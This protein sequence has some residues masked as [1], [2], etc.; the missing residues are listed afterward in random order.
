M[1]LSSKFD[2]QKF[3]VA[4]AA[5]C[6]T[7][8]EKVSYLRSVE[9]FKKLKHESMLEKLRRW[10]VKLKSGRSSEFRGCRY[11]AE[12]DNLVARDVKHLLSILQPNNKKFNCTIV[13][14]DILEGLLFMHCASFGMESVFLAMKRGKGWAVDFCRR[15]SF[16][17]S[18]IATVVGSSRS[19]SLSNHHRLK[20]AIAVDRL[21]TDSMMIK[22]DCNLDSLHGVVCCCHKEFSTDNGVKRRRLLTEDCTCKEFKPTENVFLSEQVKNEK[23]VSNYIRDPQ[24]EVAQILL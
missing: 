3:V 22:S 5:K 18:V 24:C 6:Q 15:H 1:S 11:G 21:N 7:H 23:F 19:K 17:T 14:I 13:N 12:V 9:E 2:R 8:S 10:S 4:E 16:S 20:F